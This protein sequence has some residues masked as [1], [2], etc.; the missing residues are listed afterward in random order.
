MERQPSLREMMPPAFSS[1]RLA[2]GF[3]LLLL[4]I[5]L[6]PL[7]L[8]KSLLSPRGQMY[9]STGSQEMHFPYLWQQ[10]FEQKSDIDIAFM[11]SSRIDC[12]IDTEY[13]QEQLTRKLGRPAVVLKLT[14]KWDGF[15]AFYFLAQDLLQHRK[16]RM[17]VFGDM[18]LDSA[19][20]A[21]HQTACWFRLGDN[22]EALAGLPFVSKV[23][24]Y[25]SAL[26]GIPRNLVN[27]LRHNP[28]VAP[29]EPESVS[30]YHSS[31]DYTPQT[32]VTPEEFK[33]YSAANKEDFAFSSETVPTMQLS[34][35]KK[36]GALARQYHVQLVYLRIP[37]LQEQR[38]T[39]VN[40][41]TFWPDAFGVK[42]PMVGIPP[43]ILFSGMT[44]G[45]VHNLYFNPTHFNQNGQKYFTRLVTP[46]LIQIYEDQIKP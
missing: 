1:P 41:R 4:L 15:D 20:L 13:I 37:V 8:G 19:N 44:D 18:I 3:T 7:L 45:E 40:E 34:F 39:L 14:W 32:K 31:I 46:S 10:F 5:L 23:S 17:I 33:I 36:S 25:S 2:G 21:H 9:L 24:F 38:E 27:L 30:W 22:A 35:I 28:P 12:A 11:S 42:L 26:V 29:V 16:V 6:S 43:S